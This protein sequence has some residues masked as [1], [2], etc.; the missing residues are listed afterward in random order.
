MEVDRLRKAVAY[1]IRRSLELQVKGAWP[2]AEGLKGKEAEAAERLEAALWRGAGGEG[3]AGKSAELQEVLGTQRPG[4]EGLFADGKVGLAFL[5]GE[6]SAEEVLRGERPPPPDP[7]RVYRGLF[8][9]VLMEGH[10]AYADRARALKDAKELERGCYNTAITTGEKRHHLGASWERQ[11]F[12]EYYSEVCGALVQHLDPKSLSCR[13]YG[14]GLICD[15]AEGKVK[16]EELGAWP[17]SRYCPAAAAEASE[18]IEKRKA[19]KVVEKAST[20][21]KCPSCGAKN[22]TWI[23]AQTRSSDEPATI[24]CTCLSCGK[25]FRGH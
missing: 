8:L 10:P 24:L 3:Y 19:Q 5:R 18:E 6:L 12:V 22:C 16:A 1:L 23:S 20:S 4:D 11:G 25:G 9:K 15:L 21:Y 2:P 7:R 14:A 17:A 13:A